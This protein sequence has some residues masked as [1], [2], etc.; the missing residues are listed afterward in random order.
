M[1]ERCVHRSQVGLG[2]IEK[3]TLGVLRPLGVVGV[4]ISG[5]LKQKFENGLCDLL[6]SRDIGPMECR[7]P[8]CNQDN[9]PDIK[10]LK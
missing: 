9:C 2:G 10:G 3:T 7:Q 5:D 6:T 4:Y 1:G 8:N